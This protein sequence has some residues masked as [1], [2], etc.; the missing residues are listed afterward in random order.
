[1]NQNQEWLEGLCNG[2]SAMQGGTSLHMHDL[3]AGG[4]IGGTGQAGGGDKD[5]PD[6]AD[7]PPPLPQEV[8]APQPSGPDIV[9]YES[10]PA[11]EPGLPAPEAR[12]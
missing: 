10:P 2:L 5:S 12:A 6:E 8:P 11:V 3:S 4:E 9:P 1:M 7:I